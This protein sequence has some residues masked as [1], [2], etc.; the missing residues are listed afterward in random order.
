MEVRFSVGKNE[1]ELARKFVGDLWAQA[2]G[3]SVKNERELARITGGNPSTGTCP[4]GYIPG[5]TSA[6]LMFVRETTA[7]PT[8]AVRSDKASVVT[9]RRS[10][11]PVVGSRETSYRRACTGSIPAEAPPQR[12]RSG[13]RGRCANLSSSEVAANSADRPDPST[14]S[15]Q[16]RRSGLD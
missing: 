2:L 15:Q 3:P 5:D 16:S 14:S 6:R 13:E 12:Q 10:H 1:R 7:S 9:T 11:S 4:S 8:D